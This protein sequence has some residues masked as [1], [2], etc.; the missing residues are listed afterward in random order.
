MSSPVLSKSKHRHS[1]DSGRKAGENADDG[2]SGRWT[3]EEH[4]RFEEALKLYGKD[5]KK[6][7]MH[8]RTRTTTQTRSHA[9]KYF[10][11]QEKI[12]TQDKK[13][14][15]SQPSTASSSPNYKIDKKP[16]KRVLSTKED[17]KKQKIKLLD[18]INKEEEVIMHGDH[19]LVENCIPFYEYPS[20]QLSQLQRDSVNAKPNSLP[21]ISE[22]D[23]F[24]FENILPEPVRPLELATNIQEPEPSPVH[25]EESIIPIDFSNVIHCWTTKS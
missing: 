5:W 2:T 23:D 12:E 10:A 20:Q 22:E 11:K 25:N 19:E 3:K 6:V 13:E 16:Q 15:A 24:E 4:K 18:S 7:Q 8:V 17:Q 21:Q 14:Q 9:Q 1:I